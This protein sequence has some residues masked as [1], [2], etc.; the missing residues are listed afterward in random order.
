MHYS[1]LASRLSVEPHHLDP[2]PF[3]RG[4]LLMARSHLAKSRIFDLQQEQRS[5]AKKS[6]KLHEA[7]RAPNRFSRKTRI[8]TR[9]KTRKHIALEYSEQIIM[10]RCLVGFPY[11]WQFRSS[12]MTDGCITTQA[13]HLSD[14]S[15]SLSVVEC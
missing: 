5:A 6:G 7:T 14:F 3:L 2:S 1:R 15:L 12:C 8:K 10:S 9:S 13:N 11:I 4:I